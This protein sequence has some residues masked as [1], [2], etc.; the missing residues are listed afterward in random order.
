MTRGGVSFLTL[1]EEA[2]GIT[3]SVSCVL[4]HSML[5]VILWDRYLINVENGD[6]NST[7]L[8]R[9][10]NTSKLG[11][12]LRVTETVT[13]SQD[14]KPGHLY[15]ILRSLC[16]M[17]QDNSQSYSNSNDTLLKSRSVYL[18]LSQW[19]SKHRTQS[20]ATASP[21]NL[22]EMRALR[23]HSRFPEQELILCLTSPPGNFWS[24]LKVENHRCT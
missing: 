15:E 17:A 8:I 19:F 3:Q 16:Y 24:M 10:L 7:C 4:I 11:N 21:R 5:S 23:P 6:S 20:A 22:L 14:M 2:L 18:T 9:F 1:A 12:L 13:N